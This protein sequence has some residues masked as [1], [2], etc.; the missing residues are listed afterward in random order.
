M[1]TG[2]WY[3]SHLLLLVMFAFFF[4]TNESPR[5]EVENNQQINIF[6]PLRRTNRTC[7]CSMFSLLT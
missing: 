7:V 3:Y 2:R 1:R 6:L 4:R 5:D